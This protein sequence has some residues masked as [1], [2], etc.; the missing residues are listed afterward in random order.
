MYP[1]ELLAMFSPHPRGNM[2]FVAMSFDTAHEVHWQSVISPAISETEWSGGRL[3][4]Y[5][6]NLTL[7]S[8]SHH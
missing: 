6:V 8:D 4:P 3:K 7:R 2:V 5:R 1:A